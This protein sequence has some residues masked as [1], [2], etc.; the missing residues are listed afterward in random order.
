M[1]DGVS[2]TR[3]LADRGIGVFAIEIPRSLEYSWPGPGSCL[4]IH[5]SLAPLPRCS[6]PAEWIGRATLADDSGI[7]AMETGKEKAR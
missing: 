2:R 4:R 6:P 7:V 5:A 3:A 1:V